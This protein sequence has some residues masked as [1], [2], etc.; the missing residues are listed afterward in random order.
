MKKDEVNLMD[1]ENKKP[2]CTE[3][4]KGERRFMIKLK[5]TNKTHS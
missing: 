4:K 2:G 3:K 5:K 1:K